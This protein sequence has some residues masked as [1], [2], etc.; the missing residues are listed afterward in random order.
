[1]EE[2]LRKNGGA[3]PQLM[4]RCFALHYNIA[5]LTR[6]CFAYQSATGALI[7]L[8]QRS[9][10]ALEQTGQARECLVTKFL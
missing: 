9:E 5:R 4:G 2:L 7:S 8:Q 10:I 1:M 6:P 3:S